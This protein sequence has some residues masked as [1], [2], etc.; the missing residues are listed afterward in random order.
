M[1]LQELLEDHSPFAD[2][3]ERQCRQ[4]AVLMALIKSILDND[5]QELTINNVKIAMCNHFSRMID[6][7]NMVGD[8]IEKD[9]FDSIVVFA[10]QQELIEE[11]N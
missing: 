5:N 1:T 9:V 3:I 6:D 7:D 8:D 4:R 2:F 10:K 11:F